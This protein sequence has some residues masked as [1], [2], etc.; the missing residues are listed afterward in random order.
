M[1]FFKDT[2][3][4]GV[5]FWAVVVLLAFNGATLLLGAF[6]DDIVDIPDY[7][8]DTKTYCLLVG[9]GSLISALIYAIIAHK[10][11]SKKMTGLQVLRNYVLTIG[12]STIIA[13]AFAGAAAFLCTDLEGTAQHVTFISLIAGVLILLI[14]LVMGDGKKGF[15]KKVIWFILVISFIVM[16]VYAAFPAENYWQFAQHIANFLIA[17]FMLLFIVDE[18]VRIEMGAKY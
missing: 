7:V 8:N 4:I 16:L 2:R 9:I 3:S 14:G 10:V 11:M 6:T 12:V 17:F 1:M 15:I 13:G 5:V 18:D